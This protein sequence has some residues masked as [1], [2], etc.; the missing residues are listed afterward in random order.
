MN[1]KVL[2]VVTPLS[3]YH[4]C[5]TGNIFWGG[6]FKGEENF[7]LGDFYAVNMKNCGRINVR[8]YKDIKGSD[9]Y[10]TL[11]I[12]LKLVSLDKMRIKSLEPKD[13]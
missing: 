10:V 4:F 11:D 8:K 7:T 12:S 9:K 5:S 2:E 6:K 3:I 1:M 13:N